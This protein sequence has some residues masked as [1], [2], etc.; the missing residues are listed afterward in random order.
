[1]LRI[2]MRTISH[3]SKKRYNFRIVVTDS[4]SP[5]DGK[6]VEQIGYYDPSKEPSAVKI[7]KERY[8]YWVSKGAQPSVTVKN[9]YRK[10]DRVKVAE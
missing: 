8:S 4:K 1:M 10:L 2:K 3:T 5:R 6:F 9:L 7:D